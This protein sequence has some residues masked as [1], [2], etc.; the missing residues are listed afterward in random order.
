[1]AF[2]FEL[3]SV[4]IEAKDPFW[5]KGKTKKSSTQFQ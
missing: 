5:L 1:M 2:H 4:N 3:K